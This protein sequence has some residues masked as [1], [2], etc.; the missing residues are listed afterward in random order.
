MEQVPPGQALRNMRLDWH[1]PLRKTAKAV[2]IS[3]SYLHD[4]EVGRR[5]LTAVMAARI[6]DVIVGRR[7]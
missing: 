3:P 6:A 2:G 1:R 7:G 5:R 4:L